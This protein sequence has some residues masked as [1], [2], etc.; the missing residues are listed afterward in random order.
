MC[1]FS[2]SSQNKKVLKIDFILFFN[3]KYTNIDFKSGDEM[4]FFPPAPPY[5][6]Q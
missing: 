5:C 4:S 1:S 3:R 2:S 6:V